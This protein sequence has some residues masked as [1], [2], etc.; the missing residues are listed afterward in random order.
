MSRASKSHSRGRG[1]RLVFVATALLAGVVAY[2]VVDRYLQF[3]DQP[4]PGL[5]DGAALVVAP[6]F[7][8][9]VCQ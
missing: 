9:A 7:A 3:A 2:W 8:S 5:G 6:R 4:V 1:L